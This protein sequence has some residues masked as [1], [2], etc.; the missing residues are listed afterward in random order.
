MTKKKD[1]ANAKVLASSVDGNPAT[2][3]FLALS[4]NAQTGEQGEK[5]Y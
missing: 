1:L 3:N 2:A 5:R 4:L